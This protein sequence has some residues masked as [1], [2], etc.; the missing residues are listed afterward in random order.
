MGSLK[1]PSTE[2][3]QSGWRGTPRQPQTKKERLTAMTEKRT[4]LRFKDTPPPTHPNRQSRYADTKYGAI[5]LQLKK[6]KKIRGRWAMVDNSVHYAITTRLKKQFP[7]IDW[8]TRK[9][10]SGKWD[11]WASWRLD[12]T[13]ELSSADSGGNSSL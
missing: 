6:N 12:S 11:L 1:M 2:S 8:T 13:S 10:K 5:V 3:E 9:N 4:Y 7:E